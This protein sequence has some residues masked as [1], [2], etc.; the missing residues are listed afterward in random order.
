MTGDVVSFQPPRITCT[1]TE[2]G[3]LEPMKWDVTKLKQ[4]AN[5]QAALRDINRKDIKKIDV[6]PS[7]GKGKGKGKRKGKGGPPI[8]DDT[9]EDKANNNR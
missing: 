1:I 7:K 5:G 4:M 2:Q 3:F 8:D 6:P 9:N